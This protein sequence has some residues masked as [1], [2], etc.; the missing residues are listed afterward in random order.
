MDYSRNKALKRGL[1][2]GQQGGNQNK[3]VKR[4]EVSPI[5]VKL[6]SGNGGTLKQLTDSGLSAFEKAFFKTTG[7]PRETEWMSGGDLL[8]HPTSEEQREKF[9]KLNNQKFGNKTV[10][11]TIPK[12]L[13]AAFKGVIKNVPI[14]FTEQEILN[15][16]ENQG[17]TA[18]HRII[19]KKKEN[20]PTER[21]VLFFN[22][23]APGKVFLHHISHVVEAYYDRPF[24]CEGK[25]WRLQH[26]PGRCT[27][28]AR[29]KRCGEFK[30]DSNI[31]CRMRCINCR[32][33]D[34]HEADS[35]R[36]PA[37][38]EMKEALIVSV[39]EGISSNE[40]LARIREWHKKNLG[41]EKQQPQQQTATIQ[42]QQAA[43]AWLPNP[44]TSEDFK[45]LQ[46]SVSAVQSSLNKLLTVTIPA[47]S[48][49]AD[50]AVSQAN[51][52]AMQVQELE[53]TLSTKFEASL[54]IKFKEQ[55]AAINQSVMESMTS[56]FQRFGLVSADG[57]GG[58]HPNIILETQQPGQ[59]RNLPAVTVED[60][61]SISP[62]Y[63]G[64]GD[65]FFGS[66]VMD[67][68]GEFEIDSVKSQQQSLNE[69][70]LGP[71]DDSP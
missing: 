6:L 66:Y 54:D 12:S 17:V 42:Q 26:R 14:T 67:V 9:L 56:F 22:T 58:P 41:K 59:Q 40:A 45:K 69:S 25:C 37:Y 57:S 46:D 31:P 21:V 63:L 10:S 7:P 3:Q 34:D 51:S 11:C 53:A 15:R 47:I 70:I 38:L 5:I 39:D 35:N 49:K 30:H 61:Q 18:A 33:I 71:D 16:L 60:S 8:V 44:S 29:C 64:P 43:T 52:N 20:S 36:C 4:S 1:E 23:K 68:S 32:L 19:D 28:A 50:A 13:L 2:T 62:P 48:A 27:Q 65:Q 55:Q 24:R